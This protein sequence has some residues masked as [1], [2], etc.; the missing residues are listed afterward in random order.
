MEAGVMLPL[1]YM[2]H[3]IQG[4]TL[5]MGWLGEACLV[6]YFK[7]LDIDL[8]QELARLKWPDKNQELTVKNFEDLSLL[9]AFKLITQSKGA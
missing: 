6:A 9:R 1:N 4:H 3:P 8:T 2:V 7:P 5:Q